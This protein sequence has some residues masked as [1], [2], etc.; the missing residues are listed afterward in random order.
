MSMKSWVWL[1]VFVGSTAGGFV[2]YIWGESAFSMTALF[3]SFLGG[4]IGI[5]A[6]YKLHQRF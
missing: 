3:T 2:P 4:I 1:G 6:G 5:W